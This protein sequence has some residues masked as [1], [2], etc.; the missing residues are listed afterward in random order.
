MNIDTGV[1]ALT[2]LFAKD[3]IRVPDEFHLKPRVKEIID[4]AKAQPNHDDQDLE[5]KDAIFHQTIGF[6]N[7]LKPRAQLSKEVVLKY[8]HL[9]L[10]RED[11][12]AYND[13]HGKELI[14]TKNVLN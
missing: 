5:T 7:E 8:P 4:I 9:K 1:D 6:F 11:P 3:G 2:W 14:P 12:G 10:Y 13:K